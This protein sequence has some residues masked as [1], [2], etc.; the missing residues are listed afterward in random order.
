VDESGSFTLA[1][2]A[3]LTLHVTFTPPA[4]GTYTGKLY[5]RSVSASELIAQDVELRGVTGP[6][7]YSA[8]L[9]A[10]RAT[11]RFELH[12]GTPNP[13]RAATT[14][15]FELPRASR[16]TLEVFGVDGRMR[17][18]LLD[19]VL[20]AGSHE[21]IWAPKDA[22]SGVY[23]YRLTAGSQVATRKVVFLR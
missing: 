22:A 11:G 16:V 23:F 21:R 20:P 9:A 6:R 8:P 3:S 4:A 19:T 12:A 1:P 5:L 15:A 14:I 7:P 17:E 13:A 18:R 10:E 2:G